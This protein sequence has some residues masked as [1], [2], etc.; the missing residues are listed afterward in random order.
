MFNV[1]QELTATHN[2]HAKIQDDLQCKTKENQTLHDLFNQLKKE[3][4]RLLER[5][6][7]QVATGS[8]WSKTNIEVSTE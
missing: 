6:D 1:F 7:E 3:K 4:Q 2:T 8:Y 5:V